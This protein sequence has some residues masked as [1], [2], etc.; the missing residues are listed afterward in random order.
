VE[1]QKK[2]L[3]HSHKDDDEVSTNT[4]IHSE[5]REPLEG[6]LLYSIVEF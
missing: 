2:K 5:K 6:I 4:T 1:W 3:V